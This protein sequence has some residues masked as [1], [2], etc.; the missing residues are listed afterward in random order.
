[1]EKQLTEMTVVE[2]ID[3]LASPAP[4]PGG[5]SAS[6]LVAAVGMG[7]GTMTAH[8]TT[9][10]KKFEALEPLVQ[11]AIRACL[12]LTTELTSDIDRDTE[13]FNG[14]MAALALP[15]LTEADKAARRQAV[16]TATEA[17]TRVP[18]ALMEKC[19]QAVDELEKL[20]GNIN[21]NCVSDL[22]VAALCLKTAVA[23]AW[24]N[25][26]INLGG[27]SDAAFTERCRREG[28]ALLED[29]DRRATAVYERVREQ[30][31]T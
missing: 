28:R 30:L 8:L 3:T 17:A 21:P 16:E 5:G 13:A 7:L 22:G 6:A 9:G 11:A 12:P 19:R 31:D 26:C 20:Q 14:V 18:F 29:V 25:V 23:G 24:L 4:A 15:K 2:F 10:R 27:L 1:M